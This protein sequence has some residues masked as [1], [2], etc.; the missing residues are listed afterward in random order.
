MSIAVAKQILGFLKN[1]I[2]K[3]S[4]F[5]G[6]YRVP[7]LVPCRSRPTGLASDRTEGFKPRICFA[8]TIF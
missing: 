5:K 3:F 2:L 7:S 6:R 1:K 4:L 8:G